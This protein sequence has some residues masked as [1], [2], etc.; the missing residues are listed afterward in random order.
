MST[1]QFTDLMFTVIFMT[2]HR[3]R[4]SVVIM[5]VNLETSDYYLPMDMVMIEK[6]TASFQLKHVNFLIVPLLIYSNLAL[7]LV[8]EI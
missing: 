2:R 1:D 4:W 5:I 8:K 3:F 6:L 7:P